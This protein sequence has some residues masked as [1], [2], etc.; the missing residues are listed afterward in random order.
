MKFLVM[1]R[2]FNSMLK[3]IKI[4][5]HVVVGLAG[6]TVEMWECV[7]LSQYVGGNTYY[8]VMCT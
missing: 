6:F 7:S 2:I 3:I 4:I 5:P 1:I 8:S